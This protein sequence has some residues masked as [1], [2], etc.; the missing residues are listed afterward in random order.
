MNHNSE[1]L[2]EETK[3]INLKKIRS[4]I[5][6]YKNKS[7]DMST[8]SIENHIMKTLNLPLNKSELKDK[9][10]SQLDSEYNFII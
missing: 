5:A 7:S 1:K 10:K 2:V 6:K 3:N 9:E 8:L 4:V